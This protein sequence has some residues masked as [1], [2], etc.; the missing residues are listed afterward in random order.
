MSA[1]A[2]MGP[3]AVIQRLLRPS[4]VEMDARILTVEVVEAWCQKGL[5]AV[6][7]LKA[8]GVREQVGQL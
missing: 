4:E 7:A 1:S 2:G 8:D 5:D 6:D 3:G